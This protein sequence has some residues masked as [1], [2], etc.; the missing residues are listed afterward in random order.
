MN[1]KETIL[2][3]IENVW[4][5]GKTEELVGFID[6][7]FIDHS[8][9]LG[10]PATIEGTK[11]WIEATG[12]SFQHKT[13]IEDMV[14]EGNKVFIRISMNLKHIGKWRGYDATGIDLVTT[15]YR[16]FEFA[17]EKICAQWAAI[18]GNAIEQAI[19][20]SVHTCKVD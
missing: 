6:H 2:A 16:L 4:N 18:D 19:A 20:G 3:Y 10:L 9:P 12:N 14:A 17:N 11:R 1:K 7:N 5:Q 13:I 15:G 8:L